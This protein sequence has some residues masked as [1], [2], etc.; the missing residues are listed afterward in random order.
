LEE[1]ITLAVFS[2]HQLCGAE[3]FITPSANQKFSHGILGAFN[4]F[5]FLAAARAKANPF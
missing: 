1:K 3:Q 4:L 2:I 5:C